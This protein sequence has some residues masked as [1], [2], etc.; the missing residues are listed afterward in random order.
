MRRS[1]PL[2][3]AVLAMTMPM[4]LPAAAK[5]NRNAATCA[6]RTEGALAIGTVSVRSRGPRPFVLE[7]TSTY[8][9]D[10]GRWQVQAIVRQGQQL[11]L[12]LEQTV[13]SDGSASGVTRYGRGFKG[14]REMSFTK[15]GA[16]GEMLIDGRKTAPL[17][18]GADAKSVRFE[19]GSALPRLRARPATR[20]ALLKVARQAGAG[21][22]TDTAATAVAQATPVKPVA[23]SSAGRPEGSFACRKCEGTCAAAWM[24]CIVAT[25]SNPYG[26]ALATGL[27]LLGAG[28]PTCFEASTQCLDNCHNKVGE[29]CCPIK[30]EGHCFEETATCCGSSACA[31][32]DRCGNAATGSCCP[33]DTGEFCGTG[34]CP[35]GY[36]CDGACCPNGSGEYCGVLGCCGPGQQCHVAFDEETGTLLG[37]VCCDHEPCGYSTCCAAGETCVAPETC[38][39]PNEMCN[40]TYCPL[41]G[42]CLPNGTCCQG[43][44]VCGDQCCNAFGATCCNGQC[45]N[46]ACIGGACCPTKNACGSTCC[47]DGYACTDAATG[48]C[49]PCEAGEEACPFSPGSLVSCC[50]TGRDCCVDGC[51]AA[52]LQCCAPPGS[53]QVGCH[54]SFECVR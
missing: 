43:G 47:P 33:P 49:V 46:G 51:C 52:G 14:I 18:V 1:L 6:R 8:D 32:G 10:S 48:N 7:Q 44:Q 11:V 9:A 54:Q 45:C 38:A 29:A 42:V 41:P 27:S 40:G 23:G 16:T 53:S 24:A 35:Q 19:D 30:C 22:A 3:L 15:S 21:C 36:H 2:G 39:K 50:P 34:C 12:S 26:A 31:A 28:K 20:K 37:R 25:F 13:G 17:T 5:S 4:A